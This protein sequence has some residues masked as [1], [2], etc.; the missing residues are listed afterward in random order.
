VEKKAPIPHVVSSRNAE[1]L[2]QRR[3]R[4]ENQVQEISGRKKAVTYAEIQRC[5]NQLAAFGLEPR[6]RRTKETFLLSATGVRFGVCAHNR[7]SKHI[8]SVY[9]DEFLEAMKVLGFPEEGHDEG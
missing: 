1:D 7:G 3:R 2:L 8:K 5:W 4:L 9:V 6:I